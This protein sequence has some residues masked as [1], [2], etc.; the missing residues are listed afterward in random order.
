MT[1]ILLFLDLSK[2]WLFDLP[3]DEEGLHITSFSQ[4]TVQIVA[5]PGSNS[6]FKQRGWSWGSGWPV[7]IKITNVKPVV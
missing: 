1:E 7:A 2:W 6:E 4:H 3:K 5:Y